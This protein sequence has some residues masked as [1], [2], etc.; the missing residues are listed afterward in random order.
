MHEPSGDREKWNLRYQQATD[1]AAA[2][3]RILTENRHLLPTGGTALDL[4]CGLGANALLFAESG[5]ESHAWDV[6]DVAIGQVRDAARRRGLTV[7]TQ[8]R[9]VVAEPPA[10][11]TFDVIAVSF[12]LERLLAPALI[13]ALRPAGLLFYQTYTRT[14]VDDS[15]PRNE[16]YRLMDNELLQLFSALQVLVYREEG[17]SG[18]LSRG[19]RNQAMLVG[20]KVN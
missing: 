9:D 7:H 2:P 4:A 1:E 8:V 16:A 14:R 11:E 3:A 17:R 6:S 5:L 20:R 18:D 19:W 10:A 15:G 13:A 12:F